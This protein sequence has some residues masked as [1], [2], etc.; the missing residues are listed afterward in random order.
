MFACGPAATI[1][2]ISLLINGTLVDPES[3]PRVEIANNLLLMMNSVQE[4]IDFLTAFNVTAFGP[5]T[6]FQCVI[7]NSTTQSYMLGTINAMTLIS[8]YIQGPRY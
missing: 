5:G 7:A 4:L 2:D 1:D 6:V 8:V 3:D